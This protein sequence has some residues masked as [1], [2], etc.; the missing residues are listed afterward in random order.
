MT[1]RK[2]LL[3]NYGLKAC[4]RILKDEVFIPHLSTFNRMLHAK[5]GLPKNAIL[6]YTMKKIT[7]LFC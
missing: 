6:I 3:G 5:R 7:P 1:R 4:K 2:S